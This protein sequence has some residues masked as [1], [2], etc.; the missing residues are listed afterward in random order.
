[1]WLEPGG[2]AL[3]GVAG[4]GAPARSLC[5]A[6]GAEA[7][8]WQEDVGG[9][10]RSPDE[11][12]WEPDGHFQGQL[13]GEASEGVWRD[14]GSESGRPRGAQGARRRPRLPLQG[15][16]L[17]GGSLAPREL[18]RRV[19]AAPRPPRYPGAAAMAAYPRRGEERLP[20]PSAG[21]GEGDRRRPSRR[22]LRR[23][24]GRRGRGL[25]VTSGR[26]RACLR[27]LLPAFQQIAYLPQA[28]F[29]FL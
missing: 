12:S 1:M 24:Y 2:R 29:S 16:R 23:G 4:C 11:R 7:S 22:R 19:V 10:Q 25:W 5:A 28:C 8:R 18:L 21:G 6:C 17:A 20:G 9:S 3:V 27:S 26:G 15:T 13:P 14:P